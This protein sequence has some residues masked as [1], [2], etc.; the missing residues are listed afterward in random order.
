MN[1]K[2]NGII[3]GFILLAALGLVG[4]FG[5]QFMKTS[6]AT[7]VVPTPTPNKNDINR[8]GE[9][10]EEDRIMVRKQLGCIKD[11]PCWNATVGKTKDGDNPL[12]TFDLDLNR[13]GSITQADVDLVK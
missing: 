8:S 10:D 6:P 9:A 4:Y 3:V 5:F 13:D 1:R 7:T 11:Q 2:A 12:Y